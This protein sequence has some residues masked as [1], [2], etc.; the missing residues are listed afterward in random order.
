MKKKV[1]Y[2][3]VLGALLID[4]PKAFNCIP[5]ELFIL[6]VEAYGFQTDAVNLVYDYLSNR[7]RR[8]KINKTFSSGKEIEYVVLQ[9]PI[10]GALIFNIHLCELFYFLEDL[11][12][13]S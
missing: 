1:D 3:G 5:H 8:I 9:G 12:I 10:L 6:K 11:D 4:W 2:G 13:A 7:K